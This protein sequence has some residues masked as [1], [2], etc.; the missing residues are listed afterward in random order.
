MI[1]IVFDDLQIIL[2][3]SGDLLWHSITRNGSFV[4]TQL[5]SIDSGRNAIIYS[6]INKGR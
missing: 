3:N 6:W 5:Q 4:Q 1:S 2:A